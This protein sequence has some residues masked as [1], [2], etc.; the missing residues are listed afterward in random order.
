MRVLIT[1]VDGYLGWALALRLAKAG[2]QVAGIDNFSRRG[3][4]AEMASAS[5][6]PIADMDERLPA[7][8]EATGNELTFFE[9]DLAD[10][11]DVLHAYQS[12]RPEAIVYLGEMPSAPYSMMDVRRAV[13]TQTNNVMGTLTTLF[14]IKEAAPDC[15]LV[16]LGTMGEYGTPNVDIPEGFFEIEFRGRKDRLMFPR[17]AGSW[18]HQSKVHDTHNVEMA[19]RLWGL[20]STDVMQGVVYGVRT[21]EIDGD[22]PAL[23]TRFDFDQCFGTVINRFCVQAAIGLPLTPFG[24]GGQKRSFLPLADSVQCLQL[25]VEN[26]P[27][28]GVYRTFNQFENVYSV[29][30]LAKKVKAAGARLGLKTTIQALE[31]PRIEAEEHY[32]NPDRQK[33]LDLGYTPNHDIDGE[34]ESVIEDLIPHR[35]RIL[36]FRQALSPDIHWDATRKKVGYLVEPSASGST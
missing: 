24:K 35:E 23:R 3:W 22:E 11:D 21:P 6:I 16:K 25:A 15:H 20:R 30:D 33:L 1:G 31:N 34:I 7:F 18:Y 12:F 17:R 32:Y 26:P 36:R 8:R 27:K 29:W 13:F 5:A 4:V 9:C 2:H 28:R 10:Y 14:A 19:C